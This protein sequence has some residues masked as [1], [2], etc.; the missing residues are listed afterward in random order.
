MAGRS[1]WVRV[2]PLTAE[3]KVE[4]ATACEALLEN[5]L[6]PRFIPEIRPTEDNFPIT[7]RGRWRGPNYTVYT[8]Y[9]SGF[10]ETAGEEFDAPFGRLD[11][12]ETSQPRCFDVMWY[13]HTGRW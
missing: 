10:P 3:E 11:L 12:D 2:I 1:R 4:I 5:G 9:R 13:C 6:T 7:L 8:R